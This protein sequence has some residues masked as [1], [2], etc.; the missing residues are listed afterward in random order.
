MP[1]PAVFSVSFL[2]PDGDESFPSSGR[3]ATLSIHL[4]HHY[5]LT[6]SSIKHYKKKHGIPGQSFLDIISF[7]VP[8]VMTR[9]GGGGNI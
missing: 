1:N 8:V 9:A 5:A 4:Y 7:L 2:I 6:T 3:W